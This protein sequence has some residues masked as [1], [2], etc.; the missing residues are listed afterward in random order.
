[1]SRQPAVLTLET[2]SPTGPAQGPFHAYGI[3]RERPFPPFPVLLVCRQGQR[4]LSSS[5]LPHLNAVPRGQDALVRFHHRLQ[6][7][8]LRVSNHVAPGLWRQTINKAGDG[9]RTGSI[10]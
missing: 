9:G 6:Q 8:E 10:I 5:L 3:A 4:L 7:P 1:M 2:A